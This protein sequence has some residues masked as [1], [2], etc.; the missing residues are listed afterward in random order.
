MRL[1]AVDLR[2]SLRTVGR[3]ESAQEQKSAD[4]AAY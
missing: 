4:P 1:C 2:I 3:A